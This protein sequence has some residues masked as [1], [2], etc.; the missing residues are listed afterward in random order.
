MLFDAKLN[1]RFWAEAVSKAAYLVNR[2][3]S[4]GLLTEKTPEEVWTS[5]RP[6]ISYLRVFGCKAMMHIPKEKR[7]KF[8]SKSKACIMVGYSEGISFNGSGHEQNHNQ[9]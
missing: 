8:D 4:R 2:S 7:K 5:K 3:P 9:P 6:N 1:I